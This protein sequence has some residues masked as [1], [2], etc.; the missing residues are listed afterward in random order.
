MQTRHKNKG[1]QEI[2]LFEWKIQL[3]KVQLTRDLKDDSILYQGI[4]LPCKNDQGYC[5]PTTSTQVTIV[6]FPEETCTVFQVAKIHARM[7]KFHQNFFIESS[8][9]EDVNP[10][11]IRSTNHKFGNI[12]NIENKVRRFQIYPE[13][14]LACKYNKP[15]YKHNIQKFLSNTKMVL[16]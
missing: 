6:W 3:E 5:D 13:T 7:I 2:M 12:H 8:S 10:D 4:R 14:E 16:T 11:Q 15:I 9:Y 1:Y